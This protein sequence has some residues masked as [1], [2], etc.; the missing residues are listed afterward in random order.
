[1]NEIANSK[2]KEVIDYL[3]VDLE[4]PAV[5]TPSSRVEQQKGLEVRRATAEMLTVKDMQDLEY[6]KPYQNSFS[7]CRSRFDEHSRVSLTSKKRK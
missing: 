7:R 5:D 2:I 3:H 6:H 1:M 4:R